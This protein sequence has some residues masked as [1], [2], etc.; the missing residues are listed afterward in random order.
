MAGLLGLYI[1]FQ[2]PGLILPGVAGLGCLV[3]AAIAFQIL[4]FSWVGLL[5]MGL[6]MALVASE[7]FVPAMG[8]LF[9]AGIACFLIGGSMLFDLP[10]FSD[11]DVSFWSVLVPSV[12]G[13][14]L[15]AAVV[16]FAVG[17]TLMRAQT[18]GVS[19]LLGLVGKS[20]TPLAP[21]GKVFVRG[22]YWN[23]QAEEPL[24]AGARV[25]VTA[26]DG[27]RLRVKRAPGDH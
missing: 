17:R 2:Q 14:A 12:G 26:V 22:E 9:A 25:V 6:G 8:A 27:M 4:P 3:L 11:L 20:A 7:V 24:P 16:V 15:F 21:E 10:Q 13:F 5:L 18:A 19:E 23:A 1:E